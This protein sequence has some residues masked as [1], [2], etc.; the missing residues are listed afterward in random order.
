MAIWDKVKYTSVDARRKDEEYYARAMQ[1]VQSGRRRDG[2]WAKA[3][4]STG[5]DK[6]AAK[7]A[8]IKLLVQAIRDDDYVAAR[9]AQTQ[10][11]IPQAPAH[12]SPAPPPLP[13]PRP[14]LL[15]SM[16]FWFLFLLA[17]LIFVFAFLPV[18]LDGGASIV[19]WVIAAFWLLVIHYALKKLF[20]SGKI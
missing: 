13:A 16:W 12:R 9:S 8:Y 4:T 5:G 19:Q 15:K 17:T 1:E 20:P 14:G 2:L 10:V 11:S 6:S 7:L 18:I 3:V